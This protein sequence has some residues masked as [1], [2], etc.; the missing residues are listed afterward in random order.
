MDSWLDEVTLELINYAL[1][2][3]LETLQVVISPPVL[4]TS[5]SIVLRALVVETVADFVS[6][7]YADGAIIHRVHY[8]HAERRRLKDTCGKHDLVPQRVVIGVGRWGCHP[9]A[10]AIH[11]LAD[12]G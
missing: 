9:P 1:P 10:P 8:I 4:Q 11:R 7:D 3:L 6:D 12:G 2:T 5:L